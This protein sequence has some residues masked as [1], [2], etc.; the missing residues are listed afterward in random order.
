[1]LSNRLFTE[2][3]LVSPINFIVGTQVVVVSD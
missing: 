2:E 1:M 3:I